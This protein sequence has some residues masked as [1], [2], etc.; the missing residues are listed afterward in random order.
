MS[1]PENCNAPELFETLLDPDNLGRAVILTALIVG[2]VCFAVAV[3]V[4]TDAG[5]EFERV[6]N[7]SAAIAPFLAL[8]VALVTFM[9]V[10]WRGSINQQ[11][12]L[13][14][15]RQNDSRD[16][17][18]IGILLEKAVDHL[19]HGN[20]ISNALAF[21]MLESVVLAEKRRY[22]RAVQLLLLG[23]RNVEPPIS[24]N[25]DIMWSEVEHRS[26]LE[27]ILEAADLQLSKP[28]QPS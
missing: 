3:W 14:A 7:R 5:P 26:R 24:R 12:V 19:N 22:T 28:Y 13:E 10:L 20:D 25:G 9:T 11:Q 17:V 18:E 2:I 8:L 15:K 4:F 21:S 16:N 27:A 6:R 23:I 1:E